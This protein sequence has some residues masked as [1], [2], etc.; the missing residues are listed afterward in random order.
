M[1]LEAE[2]I[3]ILVAEDNEINQEVVL[4]ILAPLKMH[5]DTANN[6]LEAVEMILANKYDLVFMDYLMPE[7]NGAE[8]TVKIRHI[9]GRDDLKTLPIV[10]LTASTDET[11]TLLDAGMNDL[12]I[13]PLS[14]ENAEEKLAMWLP[15]GS[16]YAVASS[17]ED[18][19]NKDELPSEIPA[20]EGIDVATGVANCGSW[21]LLRKLF[22][23]YG[24]V[25]DYKIEKIKDFLDKGQLDK[26]RIEVHALKSSSN[27]IGASKLSKLFETLE[28]K[29]KKGDSSGLQA[30]T[31][32]VLAL[33]HSFKH[34][35]GLYSSNP[36]AQ[37]I[38]A[39]KE[40]IVNLLKQIKY[41]ADNFYLDGVDAHMVELEK[42]ALPENISEDFARLRVLVSDVSMEQAMATISA[43]IEKLQGGEDK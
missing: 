10:A 4:D 33:Y 43:M 42:C 41:D 29:A 25:I 20:I 35:L 30:E 11:E 14:L 17:Y 2:G 12:I 31:E 21:R 13:K 34:S 37:S 24:N 3:S 7:M 22:V 40:R 19:S 6:G 1:K 23:D 39:G 26:F 36:Y 5:I 38:N 8:A 16:L 9:D 18:L 27:L 32:K 15:K 28:N